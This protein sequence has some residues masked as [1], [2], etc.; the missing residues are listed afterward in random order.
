[1]RRGTKEAL[2]IEGEPGIISR[3]KTQVQSDELVVSL[4]DYVTHTQPIRVIAVVPDPRSPQGGN[5]SPIKMQGMGSFLDFAQRF[6]QREAGLAETNAVSGADA[7][8]L[9][10]GFFGLE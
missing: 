4:S 10:R 7:T 9:T 2:I 8:A 1:L 6:G 5:S 3:F